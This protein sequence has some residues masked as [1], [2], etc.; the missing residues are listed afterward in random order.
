MDFLRGGIFAEIGVARGDFSEFLI[1]KLEPRLFVGF[2]IFL[3]H[4]YPEHWGTPSE[5][6]FNGKTQLEFYKERFSSRGKQVVTE[7]GPG[8]VKLLEYPDEY[9]DLIYIDANHS[10]ESVKR[11]ARVASQKLKKNGILIFND[12]VMFDH[13][14]NVPY[15]VVQAVN[16]MVVYDS[17][18]VTGFALERQMFC[19]IAIQRDNLSEASWRRSIV[20]VARGGGIGDVVMC[21]PALREL[22]RRRPECRIRFYTNFPSL[23]S[24]LPYIDEVMPLEAAPPN[25]VPLEYEWAVPPQPHLHLSEIIGDSLGVRITDIRPDCAIN[26][27]LVE[28][29]RSAWAGLPRPHIV[30][31]RHAS[32]WTPNKEWP[33]T[34]WMELIGRVSQYAGVIEIGS[35]GGTVGNS[36]GSGYIDLRGHTTLEECVAAIAAADLHVGPPSAPVH[37]AAAAGKRSVVIIGGYES[38]SNSAYSHDVALHTP[39]E[40]A[41]CWLR[42]PCPYGLKCLD[43]ISPHQVEGAILSLWDK[44]HIGDQSA[45]AVEP[46]PLARSSIE[47]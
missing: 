27:A 19:D 2:D 11:D 32:S 22:K 9:F 35:F 12:Y 28:R 39:V 13:F 18:C 21:T 40:C 31:S 46:N 14:A 45:L 24:G 33:E 5:I 20:D 47:S 6:L 44:I 30:V 16:E 41:P 10:Y 3:M 8:D 36:F 23:L 34:H 7:V 1:E 26:P 29:F 38:E 42:T 4:E 25:A 43:V 17:W 37:I 15:G